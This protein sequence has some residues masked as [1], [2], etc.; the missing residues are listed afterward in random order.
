MKK[1]KAILI[2]TIL[3]ILLFVIQLYY[4]I[5]FMIS[6]S[7]FL[8]DKFSIFYLAW[9][10]SDDVLLAAPNFFLVPLIIILGYIS[11]RKMKK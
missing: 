2:L 5:S 7:H 11:I 1:D 3:T 6:T 8:P 4:S 9:N 10:Q